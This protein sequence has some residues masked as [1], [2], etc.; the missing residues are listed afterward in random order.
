M[1]SPVPRDFGGVSGVLS[2]QRDDD[3]AV[4]RTVICIEQRLLFCRFDLVVVTECLS[5]SISKDSMVLAGRV[6]KRLSLKSSLISSSNIGARLHEGLPKNANVM[7]GSGVMKVKVIAKLRFAP[8]FMSVS[9]SSLLFSAN[10]GK[11][12]GE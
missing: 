11:R 5:G 9:L 1:V 4:I 6:V 12:M 2:L 8:L 10:N 3:R 7:D